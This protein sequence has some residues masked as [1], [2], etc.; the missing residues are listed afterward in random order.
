[1]SFRHHDIGVDYFRIDQQ[2]RPM[3]TQ[4]A[5]QTID[6]QRFVLHRMQGGRGW[7]MVDRQHGGKTTTWMSVDDPVLRTLAILKFSQPPA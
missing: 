4:W 3:A 2:L 7:R 5:Q 6:Q 1:M